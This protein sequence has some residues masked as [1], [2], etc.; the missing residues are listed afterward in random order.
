MNHRQWKKKFK[1]ENGRN[2]LIF[3]D[4]REFN[5]AKVKALL[6]VDFIK[7]AEDITTTFSK[8]FDHLREVVEEAADVFINVREK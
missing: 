7:V 8:A 3:E 1:K 5:K 6:K 2:P 4:K